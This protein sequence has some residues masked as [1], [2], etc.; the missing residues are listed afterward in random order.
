MSLWSR[1]PPR[2]PIASGELV[3]VDRPEMFFRGKTSM[4]VE[5]GELLIV[6]DV[7]DNGVVSILRGEDLLHAHPLD[8]PV[9]IRLP[10]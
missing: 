10:L 4:V 3:T 5:P 9:F 1:L 7:S 6:I 8:H 2:D